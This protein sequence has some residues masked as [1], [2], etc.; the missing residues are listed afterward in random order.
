MD[1]VLCGAQWK[2]VAGERVIVSHHSD[3]LERGGG[4]LCLLVTNSNSHSLPVQ[5]SATNSEAVVSSGCFLSLSLCSTPFSCSTRVA[6]SF[7]D[8][9]IN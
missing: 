1:H 4:M 7:L 2:A 9:G 3:P 5:P 8:D 6:M